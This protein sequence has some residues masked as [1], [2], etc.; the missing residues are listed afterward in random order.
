M[1]ENIDSEDSDDADD[2]PLLQ[3]K[4]RTVAGVII[5]MTFTIQ[6]LATFKTTIQTFSGWRSFKVVSQKRSQ[7]GSLGASGST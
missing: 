6:E 2:K 1:N 4:I 3:V 5:R 7:V